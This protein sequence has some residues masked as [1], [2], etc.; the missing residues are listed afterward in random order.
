M[1]SERTVFIVDDDSGVRRSL[2][3]LVMSNGLHSRTYDSAEAFLESG[4]YRQPGCVVTDVRMAGMSGFDLHERL[5][6]EGVDLPTIVI[7]GFAD[8]LESGEVGAKGKPVKLLEKTC[9][10]DELW[11]AIEDALQRV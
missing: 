7:T 1:S 8:P 9:S 4:D 3:A 6:D 10:T 11:A 2:A 5:K